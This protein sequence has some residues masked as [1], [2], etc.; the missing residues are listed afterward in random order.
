MLKT[1]LAEVTIITIKDTFTQIQ[2]LVGGKKKQL[3]KVLNSLK[4]K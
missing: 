3:K 4:M 2:F 1:L